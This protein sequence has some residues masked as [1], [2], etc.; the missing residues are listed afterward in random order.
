MTSNQS[1]LSTTYTSTIPLSWTSMT[2][3]YNLIWEG[4][5]LSGNNLISV[6]IKK[7]QIKSSNSTSYEMEINGL[8]GGVI[9]VTSESYIILKELLGFFEKPSF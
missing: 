9:K 3:E 8:P 6:K 7:Y 5:Q 4:K 2:Q 1:I